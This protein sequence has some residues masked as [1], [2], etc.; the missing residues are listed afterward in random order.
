MDLDGQIDT[1]G[2]T[3]LN[4]ITVR[5]TPQSDGD[6]FADNTNSSGFYGEHRGAHDDEHEH[7]LPVASRL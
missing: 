7:H 3:P 5:A 4:N 6:A 1:P 2:D